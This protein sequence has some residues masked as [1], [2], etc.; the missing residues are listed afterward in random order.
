MRLPFRKH[1]SSVSFGGKLSAVVIRNDKP[2][3]KRKNLGASWLERL[4]A[5]LL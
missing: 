4:R 2:I 5:K 1:E 3:K